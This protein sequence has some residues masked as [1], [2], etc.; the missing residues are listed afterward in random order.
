MPILNNMVSQ[1]F[2][3]NDWRYQFAALMA[4]SQVGEYI[5]DV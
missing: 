1:L 3:H 4:L 5:Q 2:Q